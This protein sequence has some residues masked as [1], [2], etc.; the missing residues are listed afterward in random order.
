[1]GS[2]PVALCNSWTYTRISWPPALSNSWT[3]TGILPEIR[4]FELN[5][6]P[7]GRF[8]LNLL[9]NMGGPRH[10]TGHLPEHMRRIA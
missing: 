4:P 7:F 10:I 2:P 5:R 3:N 8:L 1:M 6:R 9:V